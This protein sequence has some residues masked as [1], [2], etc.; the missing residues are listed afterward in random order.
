[1]IIKTLSPQNQIDSIIHL[2]EANNFL[3]AKNMGTI[4]IMVNIVNIF[5]ILILCSWGLIEAT[6]IRKISNP[7][8]NTII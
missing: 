4:R 7:P 2:S 3:L 6:L 8:I 1:M 5:L